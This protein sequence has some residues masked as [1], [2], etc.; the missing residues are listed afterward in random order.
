MCGIIGIL[1]KTDVAS[2]L[3]EGLLVL[4]HRGQDAAGI[5]TT[6]GK[7]FHI[8]KERGL[9]QDVFTEQAMRLLTGHSGIGHVRYPTAGGDSSEE[10]QPFYVN[11]PFGLVLAHNGN[12]TNTEA[13]QDTLFHEDLRH[14]NTTSDSETLLNIFAH[15]LF[16][17]SNRG[18]LTPDA[19]FEAVANVHLLCRGAYAVVMLI[20]GHGL[21]AFRDPYGIRPLVYGERLPGEVVFASESV[22]LDVLGFRYTRDLLPGE[23]VFV[24][25][26]GNVFHQVCSKTTFHAPCIFEYVYFA[27]P[28]SVIEGVSVYAARMAM[29]EKLAQKISR[30]FPDLHLDVIV[31]I[32]DT[33]RA[34][35]LELSRCLN[36]PYREGLVKNRYIGRTFIMPGQAKRQKSVRR[37]LNP[38]ASEFAGKNVLL[39]DDSIVR[40][41]TSRQIV[42][43]VKE[44]GAKKIYFASA[45]PPVRFPNVYG[46]DMPSRNELLA[47]AKS[48]AEIAEA[49]GADAVIYQD[50]SDLIES[51]QKYNPAL[52]CFETSCFDGQYITGDISEYYLSKIE[53]VRN[54]S[55][56]LKRMHSEVLV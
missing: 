50:L 13:L 48:D 31:P 21:L 2:M 51:V 30:D 26:N 56:R 38:I 7:I 32:P 41:N 46:I 45:S 12:L 3:Y 49:I 29:G 22:A 24:D 6:E 43:L 37:K 14:I 42:Q 1:A 17:K 33:S 5:V 55:E 35:A 19:I 34:S 16:Q 28:D 44:A 23:A 4:Q 18:K 27:R 47:T 53:A 52:S 20:A 40:G 10:A 11:S 39:V 9:V 54:D 8:K 25:F 15:E 36:V